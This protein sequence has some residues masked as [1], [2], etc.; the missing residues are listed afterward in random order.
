MLHEVGH[1]SCRL[2]DVEVCKRL[3]SHVLIKKF[4]VL[5]LIRG[6]RSLCACKTLQLLLPNFWN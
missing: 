3:G 6:H 1:Y 4:C 5:V 2:L